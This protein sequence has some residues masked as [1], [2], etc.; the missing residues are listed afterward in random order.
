MEAVC[1]YELNGST[2]MKR[3]SF[4]FLEKPCGVFV[5]WIA[6]A[7]LPF[8]GHSDLSIPV[9]HYVIMRF[10][11][12]SKELIYRDGFSL[13]REP[14]A[15][16]GKKFRV[17]CGAFRLRQLDAY[18]QKT[19]GQSAVALSGGGYGIF[20]IREGSWQRIGPYG[21]RFESFS[22]GAGQFSLRHTDVPDSDFV[23]LP[24]G[25]EIAHPDP[26]ERLILKFLL[27]ARGSGEFEL[28]M[29]VEEY[30]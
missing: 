7:R 5:K 29:R 11:L 4:L 26:Y 14:W 28:K 23:M 25:R 21:L 22:N 15:A 12:K 1:E 20:T 10:N 27:S 13:S 18:H 9:V 2:L 3:E 6:R 16:P 17:S 30:P 8:G 19:C 24:E